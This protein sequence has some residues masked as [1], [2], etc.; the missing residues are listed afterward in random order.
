MQN[1]KNQETTAIDTLASFISDSVSDSPNLQLPSPDLRDFYRDEANRV[2][3]IRGEINFDTLDIVRKIMEYNRADAG[4]DTTDRKP[5]K[6]FLDTSGGAVAVMWSIINAIKMSK[7]PV[8]TINFCEALS[9]GAHILAA[10]HKR[11]A[12]PGSTVLIHSG[13]CVYGGTQEQ[14]ESS[15]KYY[16]ALG[17]KANDQLLADTKIDAKEFKR[18]SAADWYLSDTEALDRGIVDII[19]SDFDE[20][21]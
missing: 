19:V 9:A 1:N 8:Y 12:M 4:I 5:V 3:W 10:G 16:D 20:I 6:L 11:F 18:K 21:M 14:V 17:K 15:K 7:T 2:I 13:S